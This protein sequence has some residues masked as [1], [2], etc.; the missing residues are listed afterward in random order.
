MHHFDPRAV[1]GSEQPPPPPG[2]DGFNGC[3]SRINFGEDLE[4][5]GA[6]GGS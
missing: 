1:G 2:M 4:G 3:R 5:E 6:M